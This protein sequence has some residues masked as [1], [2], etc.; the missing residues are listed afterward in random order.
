MWK[1]IKQ[2]KPKKNTDY[3]AVLKVGEA[4]Y[5]DILAYNTRKSV[6]IDRDYKE[7]VSVTHW[8]NIP[9]FPCAD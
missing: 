7:S 8:D 5:I 1:D 4:F 2:E 3:L 6:W 9:D